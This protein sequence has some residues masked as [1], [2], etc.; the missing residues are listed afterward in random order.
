MENYRIFVFCMEST[1]QQKF[2]RLLQKELAEVFQRETT[3]LLGPAY[4]SVTTVRVTPDLASA[5]VYLSLMLTNNPQE[6][7]AEIRQQTK[8]V[9]HL[10]AQR[11]KKQVRV[12]PDLQFYLDDTAEYAAH[13]DKLISG[14]DI[15]PA[16]PED[17]DDEEK[18]D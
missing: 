3:H 17:E 1:R 15:P 10:L 11:I 13:M 18:E 5:K 7:I 2:A 9:R 6:T 8:Q 12:I 16:P 14:L 4:V